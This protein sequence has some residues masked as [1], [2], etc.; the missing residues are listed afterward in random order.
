MWNDIPS[1][2]RQDC[3]PALAIREHNRRV[4]LRHGT[5]WEP[6]AFAPV[7]ERAAGRIVAHPRRAQLG[8]RWTEVTSDA[9]ENPSRNGFDA[10][11]F[12]RRVVGGIRSGIPTG[13]DAVLGVCLRGTPC[14][15]RA[16][17]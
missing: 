8:R 9:R 5:D 13:M 2:V 3:E 12:S 4:F 7:L 1:A 14:L 11:R 16:P 15:A 17:A 6:D 10:N